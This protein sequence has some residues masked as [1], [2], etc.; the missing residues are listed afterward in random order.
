MTKKVSFLFLIVFVLLA[1]QAFAHTSLQESTPNDGKVVT[2]P[3]Q[4][5][6]LI[7]G[8]KVE[9]TSKINVANSD[10]EPIALGN[11]VIE[12]DEMWANFFQ[13]L[14]NG[15]Y[16]VEWSIVGPDGHPIEGAFSFSVDV[17]IGEEPNKN[18]AETEEEEPKQVEDNQ[19]SATKQSK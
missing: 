10:G 17:P 3:I 8:T 18:F 13:P 11:F 5:L 19:A 15:N 1:N 16:D 14:E 7:F 6:S 2:E 9:Q 4:E 12:D